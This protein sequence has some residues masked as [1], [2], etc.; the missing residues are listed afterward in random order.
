MRPEGVRCVR[1]KMPLSM[2][3]F[4]MMAIATHALEGQSLL[5][6]I[7]DT[8]PPLRVRE[9][10]KGAPIQRNHQSKAIAA[11]QKAIARLNNKEKTFQ[12]DLSLFE[13]R[14]YQYEKM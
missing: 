3:L 4:C 2:S 13:F 11:E 5:L 9:W 1:S 12:A 10:I 6:N 14:L 8:A 7:G